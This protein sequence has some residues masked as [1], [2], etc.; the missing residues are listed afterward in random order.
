MLELEPGPDRFDAVKEKQVRD[1]VNTRY[2]QPYQRA[3]YLF[4]LAAEARR[5]H[6]DDYL[7][8]LPGV[9]RAD[10][11]EHRRLLLGSGRMTAFVAGNLSAAAAEELVQRFEDRLRDG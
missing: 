6:V 3:M 1:Y 7:A 9:S 2:E 10:L 8:C 5:W 4:S 11:L